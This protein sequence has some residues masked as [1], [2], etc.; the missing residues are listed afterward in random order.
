MEVISQSRGPIGHKIEI[1]NRLMML[2][3]PARRNAVFR[4][5]MGFA[6][7][8]F[9]SR[10]LPLRF[11]SYLRRQPFSYALQ[12]G[13][14]WQR[15][16]GKGGAAEAFAQRLVNGWRFYASGADYYGGL[17]TRAWKIYEA[18]ARKAGRR[19]REKALYGEFR[20]WLKRIFRA[21]FERFYRAAQDKP[22]QMTGGMMASVMRG[23]IVVRSTSTKG[24]TAKI[25]LPY[26][27][28]IRPENARQMQ[29]VPARELPAIARW[30]E[31][32]MMIAMKASA[33]ESAAVRAAAATARADRR[34]A[35][36]IQSEIKREAARARRNAERAAGVRPPRQTGQRQQRRVA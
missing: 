22:L 9:Q 3:K 35:R 13:G 29:A 23:S 27:H 21:E 14:A 16:T 15:F 31:E 1:G 36:R 26:G 19:V 10:L 28:P 32:A 4:E 24:P 2:W 11:T 20:A 5:A 30:F 7:A 6:A 18:D 17:S 12:R 25:G 34:E 33:D 8:K